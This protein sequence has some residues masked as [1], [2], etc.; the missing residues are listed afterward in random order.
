MNAK[1][2]TRDTSEFDREF[3]EDTF[4]K[5]DEAVRDELA[6]AQRKPGCPV[7]GTGAGAIFLIVELDSGESRFA[8]E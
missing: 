5:P 3:V 4:G 7:R 2:P 8:R 1:K 6:R